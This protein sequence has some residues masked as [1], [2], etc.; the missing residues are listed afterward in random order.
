M[1]SPLTLI[2]LKNSFSIYRFNVEDDIPQEIWAA[3]FASATKTID[4]LSIV[5]SDDIS[6]TGN[7]TSSGWLCFYVQGPLPHDMVGIMAELSGSL[8]KAQCSIF[9]LS[10]YDTDY[11][12]FKQD[13]ENLVATELQKAGHA[14]ISWEDF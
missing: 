13:Q 1:K 4:E 10:T 2:R 9:A 14:L 8:A 5:V 12:L 3:E 7:K 6:L 11:I